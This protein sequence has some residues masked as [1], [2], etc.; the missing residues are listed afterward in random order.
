M[1]KFRFYIEYGP[2][3]VRRLKDRFNKISGAFS[4]DAEI[5][6]H[7]R[8]KRFP[9]VDDILSTDEISTE[10]A[11]RGHLEHSRTN[12]YHQSQDQLD[13]KPTTH[14]SLP[15]VVTVSRVEPTPSPAPQVQGFTEAQAS[16]IIHNPG[17]VRRLVPVTVPMAPQNQ[18]KSID[19]NTLESIS[20][21]RA[22]FERS[23]RRL[24]AKSEKRAFRSHSAATHEKEN[25]EPEF[26]QVHRRLKKTPYRG[27]ALSSDEERTPSISSADSKY[28]I[29]TNE[30]NDFLNPPAD[31]IP[32]ATHN[33][34]PT[35]FV[36]PSDRSPPPEEP[37]PRDLIDEE[38]PCLSDSD[39]ASYD[40]SVV[41]L[42]KSQ[43]LL[44]EIREAQPKPCEA[45]P[46]LAISNDSSGI[47]E[48]H[49]L[50]SRFRKTTRAPPPP[51]A[52][53]QIKN[54]VSIS[55]NNEDSVKDGK[56]YDATGF[57]ALFDTT[58]PLK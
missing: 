35:V 46:K 54:I 21:L 23:S 36:N 14:A 26:L 1:L 57:A 47:D 34:K 8:R 51:A 41:P 25:G 32:H 30:S 18:E 24:E 16:Y 20:L 29:Q 53:Q 37:Q 11:R 7:S 48:M 31:P 27:D 40:V 2:G 28:C 15:P 9:S 13:L 58:A 42:A 56:S 44:P 45:T 22:K 43:N 33:Q 12:G 38:S 55:V 10:R 4:Q 19:E 52:E 3:I 5:S 17:R 6:P 49:R 39:T 50:L